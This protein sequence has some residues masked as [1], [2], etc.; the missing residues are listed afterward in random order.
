MLSGC[1]RREPKADLRILNGPEIQSLDPHII[2]GQAD[3]RVVLS[4][5]E[6]LTRFSPLNGDG[7]PAIAERWDISPNG[8]TY[9]FHL[10]TNAAWSTG[11]PITAEDFVFSWRRALDARTGGDYAALLFYIKNGEEF[12]TGKIKDP[13]E[14]G[15]KALDAHTLRVELKNPTPFLLELCASP[16]LAVVPKPAIER[17]GDKWV[18]LRPFPCSGA[19]TLEFWRLNDRARVRKNPHYWDATN[20]ELELVDFIPCDSAN[21]AINIYATGHA[22]VLWDKN[23]LPTDLLDVLRRRPD[24]HSYDYLGTYFIRF[25]VTRKPFTDPRV[26]KALALAVDKERIVKRIT[27]GGEKSA[28]HLTPDGMANYQPPDG[29][30]YDP[31]AARRLLRDAG[32]PNGKDFPRFQFLFN[33][34]PA[35]Q[36]IGV[37]L[38]AMWR[39]ELGL[40]MDLR[41]AEQKVFFD[42]Q[43]KLNYDVCRSSWIGDYKDPNTFLDIFIS[44]SGNNR[45]GWASPSYDALIAQANAEPN[46]AKRAKLLEQAEILLVRDDLPIFPLYFYSGLVLFDTNHWDGIGLQ[47][48]LVDQH[49]VNFIKRKKSV[50]RRPLS[51]VHGVERP[52]DDGQRTTDN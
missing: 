21:T 9:I 36:Q 12:N 18:Q 47:G 4:L 34:G 10:R 5:F 52:A 33:P 26:R 38:Q 50:V 41:Q 16:A 20:T 43:S 17:Y 23:L 45:T 11:D 27:R 19:Y 7:I 44:N 14:L 13:S 1:T 15:A 6:G 46:A 40:E 29:L 24:C 30:G 2:T 8:K 42:D 3:M 49:N 31:D 37:E 28:S 25:N 51:V 39:T 32:Y 22:D 35:N 48:N